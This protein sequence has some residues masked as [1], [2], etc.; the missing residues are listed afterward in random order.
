MANSASSFVNPSG[1]R[2][3]CPS[4]WHIPSD[5]EWNALITAAGGDISGT[6]LKAIS[7]WKIGNGYKAGTDNYGFAALPGGYD[8]SGGDF[9][10]VGDYGIWWSATESHAYYAYYRVMDYNL[11]GVYYYDGSKSNLRSVRCLQ[12]QLPSSSNSSIP[13]SSSIVPSSSSSTPL[14]LSSSSLVSTSGTFTDSRD[15]KSYKWVTIGTQTWM[16]QNLN[17]AASGSKCGDGNLLSNEDTY[18]CNTYGRLYSWN[19]AVCPNG[20]HIPSVGE[21]N[22]LISYA[23]GSLVAGTKLKA[24]GG[25]N[26]NGNGQD[27]YGFSALP[28]GTGSSGGVQFL[29]VGD[30]GKWWTASEGTSS[31]MGYVCVMNNSEAASCGPGES[32]GTPNS[33]RCVQN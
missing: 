2:G 20:W 26:N 5:A 33:V 28:G 14:P 11:E 10:N 30:I 18:T 27:T 3:I 19:K 24:A 15:N 4:G 21:W 22:T 25:W 31:I 8:L 16:A 12:D 32:K 1:V 6:N 23:G 17:Y 13:S 9:Y 7:G 29:N